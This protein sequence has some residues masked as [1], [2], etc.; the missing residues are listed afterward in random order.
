MQG[1]KKSALLLAVSLTMLAPFASAAAQEA[2]AKPEQEQIQQESK[3]TVEDVSAMREIDWTCTA[4]QVAEAEGVEA[5][6]NKVIVKDIE[7]YGFPGTL[8]Y[9]FDEEGRMVSRRFKMKSSK[10]A[11]YESQVYSIF[12]RY[13]NPISMKRN[14][15][16]WR[17]EE[18]RVTISRKDGNVVTFE[19][20]WPQEQT[21]TEELTQ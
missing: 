3:D 11:I 17:T 12:A 1:I 6:K 21:D 8:T 5:K 4:E 19:R 7:L 2:I 18:L 9:N 14:E 16:I 13:G 20:I 10:S 15:A